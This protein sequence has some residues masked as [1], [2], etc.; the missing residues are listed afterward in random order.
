MDGCLSESPRSDEVSIDP[1]PVLISR[2]VLVATVN[3]PA[4]AG[5]TVGFSHRQKPT[6]RKGRR[7]DTVAG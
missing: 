6:V 3:R 2:R 1:P 7:G 5:L 4:Y